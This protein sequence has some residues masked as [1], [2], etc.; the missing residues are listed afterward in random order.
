MNDLAIVDEILSIDP[1]SLERRPVRKSDVVGLFASRSD[2]R[3]VRIVEAMADRDGILDPDA[4]DRRLVRVHCERQRLSEEFRRGERLAGLLHDVLDALRRS[5]VPRPIRIV[6]V[7]CGTGYLLRWLAARAELGNDVELLGA[8]LH[9]ALIAEALR[10]AA[11]ENLRVT[12][13]VANAF[14]LDPPAAIGFS[15]GL[16]H[17]FGEAELPTFF[18]AQEQ[19][20]MRAFV[21]L[22]LRPWRLGRLFRALRMRDPLA[23]HDELVSGARAHSAAALRRAAVDGA[24]GF[25]LELR[26]GFS[27]HAIVGLRPE[28]WE[29]FRK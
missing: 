21:H 22:D 29:A 9:S 27:D 26:D 7:S 16:L 11:L 24:P 4:V 20:G 2:R 25:E 19:A 18:G 1:H 12:F 10:L 8:D 6:D 3:A 28:A 15:S 13:R 5:G 17:R 23:R 14:E